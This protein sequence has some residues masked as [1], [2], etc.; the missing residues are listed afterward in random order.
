MSI[1]ILPVVKVLP[2]RPKLDFILKE[3]GEKD[4]PIDPWAVEKL[5]R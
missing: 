3:S 1:C 2:A 5:K 4:K